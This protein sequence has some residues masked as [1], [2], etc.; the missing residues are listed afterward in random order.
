MIKDIS[1]EAEPTNVPELEPEDAVIHASEKLRE[2]SVF[3]DHR[4]DESKNVTEEEIQKEE[5]GNPEEAQKMS[6]RR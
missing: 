6:F 1:S 2:Q 3:S 5:H 4:R